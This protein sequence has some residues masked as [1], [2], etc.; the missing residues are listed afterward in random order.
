[1][2][3]SAFMQMAVGEK[4]PVECEYN[5]LC[6]PALSVSRLC[7]LWLQNALCSY[8]LLSPKQKIWAGATAGSSEKTRQSFYQSDDTGV[9]VEGIKVA[10]Q[11]ILYT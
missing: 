3:Q 8:E 4:L 7:L 1:M 2:S 10:A 6:I 5:G 11:Y 9:H